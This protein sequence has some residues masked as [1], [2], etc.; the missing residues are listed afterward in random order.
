MRN[1]VAAAEF[2][3]SRTGIQPSTAI[4]LGSGLGPVADLVQNPVVVSNA[5]VPDMPVSAVPGHSGTILLGTISNE[6]VVVFSGRVHMYEGHSAQDVVFTVDL[7]AEMGAK[8]LI[9]TNAAGAVNPDFQVGTVMLIKD[10]INMLPANPMAGPLPP[11][12]PSRFVSM[13]AAYDPQLLATAKQ[14]AAAHDIAVVDGVYAAMPG[15]SFETAAEVRM[16]GI[17]G[18]DAAGMSTVPEVIRAAWHGM[19]TLGISSITNMGTGLA[20]HD[21]NH[22]EVTKAAAANAQ[23]LAT[24]I[25]GVCATEAGFSLNADR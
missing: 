19:A 24:I 16:L 1:V 23:K 25:S 20:V 15:P 14:V 7:A 21:H 3:R 6:P 17:L 11:G 10:H 13:G 4:I 5:D 2:L 22:A 18:G 12:A 9:T 8:R